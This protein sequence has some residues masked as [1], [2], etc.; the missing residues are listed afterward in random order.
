MLLL[1]WKLHGSMLLFLF[2]VVVVGGG[3]GGGGGVIVVVGG[4]G[5]GGGGGGDV[6]SVLSHPH[7]HE[8]KGESAGPRSA[9]GSVFGCRC[10]SD[11]RSRGREF[12]PG[13]VPYFRGD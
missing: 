6:K 12:D 8:Y 13:P 5:G 9:V 2:A 7:T 10:V 4:G 3:G 11:C 1:S